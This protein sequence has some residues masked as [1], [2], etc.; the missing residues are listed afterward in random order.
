MLSK[1]IRWCLAGLLF[2]A[3]KNNNAYQNKLG[4]EPSVV[5]EMD[6]AHYTLIQ[7]KDTVINFGT[8]KAGD[9]THLKFQFT[10]IGKTPLAFDI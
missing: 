3:C 2:L 9:S 4:I 5:A 8:L 6:T 1:R 7:W 10:N